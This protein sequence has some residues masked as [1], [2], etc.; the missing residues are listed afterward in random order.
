MKNIRSILLL[1]SLPMAA[2]AITPAPS[3]PGQA[4]G[5]PAPILVQAAPCANCGTVQSMRAYTQKGEGSGVGAVTGGILG[6]VL[7]HQVG[8]GRGKDLATVA[9]AAGGAYA[10]HQ[11]ERNM[12]KTTRWEIT[13]AMDD[14]STRKLNYGSKPAVLEGDRIQLNGTKI[15]RLANPQVAVQPAAVKR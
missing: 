2:F 4:V 12:K 7:G 6:G 11:V 14:G 9:G 5:A 10:G 1:V 3:Q 13:L 8:G 15:A